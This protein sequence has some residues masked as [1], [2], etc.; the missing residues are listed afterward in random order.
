MKQFEGKVAIVTGGTSGIG[1]ATAI[2]YA[3]EGAKVAVTGRREEKGLET[4]ELIKEVGGEGLFIQ[5]DVR[6]ETQVKA[7]VEKT[8]SAFGR[9]DYAFNN[10][11]VEQGATKLED[12]L[13]KYYYKVFDTNVK[14]VWLS[15]KY[16]IPEMLKV[17]G[18]S[19]VNCSSVTGEVAMRQIPLYVSSKHAVIGLTKGFALD[20]A[21]KKIRVNAVSPAAIE[22][23]MIG[24]LG[25]SVEIKNYLNSLHPIGRIGKPEEVAEAVIWL[26]SDKSSFVTGQTILVDGGYTIQ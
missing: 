7:M 26:S 13:E 6:D 2:A 19:I 16:Q 23:D 9:L 10:A 5:T 20:F 18:G 15:M 25:D 17:G 11:G 1:R 21:K 3:R 22:T 24:R 14:G 8:V 4:V 12:T